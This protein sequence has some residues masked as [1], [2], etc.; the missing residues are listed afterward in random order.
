MVGPVRSALRHFHEHDGFFL[1]AGLSFY[2][3]IC[4]LP[5]LLL[6][7]TGGA[8]LISDDVVLRQ[9]IER[10][11]S[12]L[13]VYQ[14]EMEALVR[15]VVGA[16]EVGSVVGTAM[17]VLFASQLFTATRLVL[18]RM[19]RVRPRSFLHGA[20]FDLGM[21]VV[22]GVL[23]L[24]SVAVTGAFAWVQ[25]LALLLGRGRVVPAVFHWAGLGLVLLLD[26]VLFVV[27]FRFVPNVRL[28]WT[29]VL[30]GG[31]A[32]ATLWQLAKQAFRWY[33]ERIALYSAVYGSFGVTVAL[34]MWVYY[35]AIV[36]VLG[37]ALIR[38]LEERR[39]RAAA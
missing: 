13:P 8:F 19:F 23:F 17:L 10:L 4:L 32:T 31:L 16:R 11:S 9:L 7:V 20:L 2:V 26:T 12:V 25:G 30:A 36:F 6:L 15:D 37:A 28:G 39:L 1:A 33:I 38:A 18:N 14:H 35:S 22:L 21:M 29:S 3:V 27:L 24:V 5:F 34:V